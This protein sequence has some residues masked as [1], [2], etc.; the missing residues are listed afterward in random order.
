L[1]AKLTR[2]MSIEQWQKW[3]SREIPFREQCPRSTAPH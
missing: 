1:C 3:L 2:D